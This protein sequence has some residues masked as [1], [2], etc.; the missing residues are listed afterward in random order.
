MDVKIFI[1]NF[2]SAFGEKPELPFVF[3]Y[4]DLAVADTAKVDGCFFQILDSVHN[5]EKVSLCAENIGCG[6]GK[7]YTGFSDM[8]PHIP[9]FVSLKEKYKKTP[10]MVEEYIRNIDI[11]RAKNRYLNFSRVDSLENF[12]NIEG[13]V[14]FATPD[15]LSGLAAW[16]FFDNNEEDA[17]SVPFGS[18]CASVVSMAVRE[19][20]KGGRRTFLGLFDPSVRRFVDADKLS[21]L[22]PM[23]R[24]REMYHTMRECCLFNTRAWNIIKERINA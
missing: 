23:S 7:L 10:E 22:I 21:F 3:W 14:F 18:G 16:A 2:M 12:E 17:V 5:G 11:Q 8:S 6:G 9:G 4:S 1:D 13:L 19:N 24:F 20:R 15:E